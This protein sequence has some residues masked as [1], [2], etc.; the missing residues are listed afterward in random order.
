M[1]ERSFQFKTSL[2]RSELFDD[3]LEMA[4]HLLDSGYK[5]PAAVLVGGVLEQQLRKLSGRAGVQTEKDG[6][7]KKA[8]LL[9]SELVAAGAY[10]KLDQKSV[11]SWLGLRNQ[12]AHGKYDSYSVEQTRIMLLGVRDFLSRTSA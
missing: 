11:T 4:Q 9:N 7:P 8:D 3:F 6:I 1:R 12:A 10:G 2:I 5:D